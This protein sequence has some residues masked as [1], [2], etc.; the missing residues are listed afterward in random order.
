MGDSEELAQIKANRLAQLQGGQGG[1]N[2]NAQRQ[3]EMAEQQ[4]AIKNSILKQVLDQDALARLATLSSVKPDKAAAV[5][6]LIVR[7]ARTGQLGEKLTD[8]GLKK[9]LDQVAG[10]Q[11]T[12]TVKFD[13]RRAALDSDDDDY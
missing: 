2:Q 5:E 1:S 12:T 11:K 10:Q 3:K 7:M 4:E 6:S 8:D 13:R 9:L